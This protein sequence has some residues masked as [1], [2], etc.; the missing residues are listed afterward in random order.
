MKETSKDSFDLTE[1]VGDKETSKVID[2]KELNKML[3]ANKDL[4]FAK[5]YVENDRGKYKGI[6]DTLLSEE[7][8]GG[9]KKTTK[10]TSKKVSKK[11]Q[12]SKKKVSKKR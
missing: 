10:K 8:A 3:K 11:K 9:K 1:K 4:D 5:K 2:I 6:E 12:V 7:L